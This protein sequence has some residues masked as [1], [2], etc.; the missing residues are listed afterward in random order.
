M[1]RLADVAAVDDEL[2]FLFRRRHQRR[3]RGA[4]Q[5]WRSHQARSENRDGRKCGAQLRRKIL[6]HG[7]FLKRT[8]H[9]VLDARLQGAHRGWLRQQP[10][11]SPL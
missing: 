6:C 2:A 8:G 10:E 11:Y 9:G 3:I 4:G 7:R 5:V 1:R